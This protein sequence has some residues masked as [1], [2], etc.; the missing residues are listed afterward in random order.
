MEGKV[1]GFKKRSVTAISLLTLLTFGKVFAQENYE[2]VPGEYLIKLKDSQAMQIQNLKM[3]AEDLNVKI[4]AKIENQN[5]LIVKRPAVELQ[6]YALKSLS[7]S[8]LV[9]IVEPN[10]IYRVN[11]IPNDPRFNELW[12]MKNVGQKDSQGRLGSAGVDVGAEA[13]WD[14][15]TGSDDVVVAVIDT[16][17]NYNQ[18]DLKPNMWVNSAELNGKP[19]IDDDKNGVVDD[20]H[21]ASFTQQGITG[22]PMDDHGHG[23]HCAGT[24]GARGNDGVGVAGVAWSVKIMG[25]KFLEATGGGTLENA[26]RSIDYATTMGAKIL[27]NSWGGGGESALLKEAIQRSHSAGTLFVAAA[28][29]ESN[30]NDS[31]PTFPA[32]YDVPNVLSVAALDNKGQIASFS[33]YGKRKVHVAAPG[34]NILSTIQTG[35]DS[36]S[37][38]SMAAPHVSGIAVLLAAQFPQMSGLEIKQRIITTSNPIAGMKS[39]VSSGGIANAYSALINAQPKPDPNDPANWKSIS[40]SYSSAHPY[41]DKAKETFEMGVPGAKEISIYFSR[42][43]TE[44]SF[45]KLEI[46]DGSG[47]LIETISGDNDDYYSATIPGSSAKLIFTSDDSVTKY[48]FD[49]TRIAY[50]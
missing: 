9:E 31:N 22:N 43:A 16:G 10:Y 48:G 3:L 42:F 25:L 44:R 32:T 40:V 20:I 18:P 7:K 50:R 14:I 29:N 23:S 4:K 11:R 12:G 24:I 30:N 15:T 13:A 17:I 5:I 1:I 37:G 8:S 41:Q 6:S 36:W 46:F 39:R 2:A 26:I 28:G 34:V 33:N 49:I 35:Y 45:D 21:G 47:K 38:T 19:G 27:S